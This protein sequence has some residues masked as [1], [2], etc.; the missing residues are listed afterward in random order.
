MADGEGATDFAG[1]TCP[2]PVPVPVRERVILGHGGGGALS[3]ELIEQVFL[4]AF[5]NPVLDRLGDSSVLEVPGG[6][7]SGGRLAVST[8]SYVVR[9]LVFPGG[10]I[11][12]LAVNGTVN[13][14][15]MSGAR[16]LWLT[17]AFIITEG[18]AV[19]DLAEIARCMARAAR[20]AGVVIV[21]GDTKVVERGHGDG[22]Y[23]NT[24]GIGLVPPDVALGP[25]RVRPGDVVLVSGTLADH[26]MAVMSVREGLEFDAPI[27]SDTAPLHGLVA[28]ML[29]ACPAV[30]MLRDPTRG[31]AATSLAEIAVLADVGIEIDEAAIPVAAPVAAAC[32]L[33]GLDPLQVA[34]EGKLLAVVPAADADAVL[35]AMR[36]HEHGRG[37]ERLGRVVADHPRL[38]VMR[39]TL[40]GTRIVPMPIGEQL[41][42]IC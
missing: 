9:P 40:G 14:L 28:A 2:V 32:E 41:P 20:A 6:L 36:A 23:V 31:G 11:G 4:P 30:R 3:H 26:G 33:L 38:V 12:D 5:A 27:A 29:A 34:N 19:E 7:A 39:T 10:T 25:D 17:A 13:D 21:T 22:C 18:F 24:T 1:L 35:A 37:A 8:D 15:A 16:P 42:R